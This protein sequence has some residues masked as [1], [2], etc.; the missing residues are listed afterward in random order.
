MPDQSVQ[1]A[2]VEDIPE[3]QAKVFSVGELR[4]VLCK[5]D[6]TIYAIEDL[7]SHDD[8]PLGEGALVGTTIECPRHGARFNVCTGEVVRMPAAIPVRTFQVKTE[9]NRVF[10]QVEPFDQ[11]QGSTQ[12][13]GAQRVEGRTSRRVEP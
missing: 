12:S 5:V 13:E 11:A 3:G 4:I 6:G 1:V 2:S 10:V 7:C 9:G 8:G